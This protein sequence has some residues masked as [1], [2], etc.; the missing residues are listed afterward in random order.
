MSSSRYVTCK[1]IINRA[2][3]EVGLTPIAD[4]FAST[5]PSFVQLRTLLTSCGQNL[6][7][8]YDWQ[9]LRRQYSVTT[10][11]TELYI[12]HGAFSAGTAFTVGQ[13]VTGATSGATGVIDEVGSGYVA[14]SSVTGTFQVG[15]NISQ[16]G[17]DTAAVTAL[18]DNGE[19]N[20]PDDFD[21]MID[22]TNWDRTNRVPIMGPLSPQQWQYLLGMEL[23]SDT[24]YAMFRIM[25]GL[26]N[27][28]PQ[29]PPVGLNVVYEY[30]S[31]NWIQ[32]AVDST[33]FH[34]VADANADIVLFNPEMIIQY[35]RYKF[36]SA[37]GF[38]TKAAGD[39]FAKAYENAT[40]GNKGAPILNAGRRKGGIRFLDLSNIPDSGYGL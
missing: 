4:P 23:A 20:L 3:T 13:T 22:Q 32:D 35:L 18:R 24:I 26:F 7:G 10:I 15:E 6:V 36:L 17:P 9:Q 37:K 30:I 5:D 21:R 31:I 39:D 16:P 14:V 27:I 19:Y 38:A 25:D 29:P 12:E 8:S 11:D 2:A 34:N 33:E 28:L 1:E 40:G